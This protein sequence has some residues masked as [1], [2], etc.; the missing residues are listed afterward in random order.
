MNH[1]LRI[2]EQGI[3]AV[4]VGCHGIHQS[5]GIGG[6]VHQQPKENLYSRYYNRG[7]CEQL[8]FYFVAGA[9]D[10]S[11]PRQPPPP[12]KKGT[13]LP[14]PKHRSPFPPLVLP[15]VWASIAD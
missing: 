4:A 7:A 1:H 15:T 9:Q 14:R 6:K 2:L 8:L 10:K 13:F 11:M 5:E 12:E 3:K